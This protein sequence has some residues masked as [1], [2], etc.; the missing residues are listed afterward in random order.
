MVPCPPDRDALR[1]IAFA[2]PQTLLRQR[3]RRNRDGILAC[4]SS[5]AATAAAREMRIGSYLRYSAPPAP[6]GRTLETLPPGTRKA[7]PHGPPS[8]KSPAR[9][10]N[11]ADDRAPHRCDSE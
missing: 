5:E 7:P 11:A 2:L 4:K 3:P 6:P 1:E 10:E 8:P 9:R